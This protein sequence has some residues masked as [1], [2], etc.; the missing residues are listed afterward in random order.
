[1][2][3]KGRLHHE[4]ASFLGVPDF[5]GLGPFLGWLVKPSGIRD[6]GTAISVQICRV[7]ETTVGSSREPALMNTIVG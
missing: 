6:Q 2:D 4:P 1:M 3:R 5:H 7:G